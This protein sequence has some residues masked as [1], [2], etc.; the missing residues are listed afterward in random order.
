SISCCGIYEALCA[1]EAALLGRGLL[2][3]K[4]VNRGGRVEV[5][6]NH[7]TVRS[8]AGPGE[9]EPTRNVELNNGAVFIAHK[10]VIHVCIVNSP[11]CDRSIRIDVPRKCALVG[12]R[13]TAGSIECR[14]RA[15]LI[16][17]EA[18]IHTAGVNE[19]PQDGSIR[20]K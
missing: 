14:H 9:H 3:H 6:S 11:S 19:D 4:A 1:T 20:T 8:N 16:Q 10:A 17:Q 2:S 13:T 15:M 18:V 7:R 5:W 12:A